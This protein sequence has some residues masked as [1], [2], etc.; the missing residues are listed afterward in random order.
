VPRGKEVG[1]GAEGK[2]AGHTSSKQLH[3][4]AV[5]TATSWD[6]YILSRGC[7]TS[8]VTLRFGTLV[9]IL[10]P[11]HLIIIII[12]FKLLWHESSRQPKVN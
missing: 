3:S 1:K 12:A 5:E 4:L 10:Q 6:A 8:L 2:G 11:S 7:I 9:S